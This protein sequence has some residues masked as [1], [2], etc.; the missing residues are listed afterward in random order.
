MIYFSRNL[1]SCF[2]AASCALLLGA[3]Q[4]APGFTGGGSN[5]SYDHIYT[6]ANTQDGSLPLQLNVYQPEGACTAPRP[7]IVYVH[8][9]S[10]Y[11]GDR[12]EGAFRGHAR[13]FTDAGFNFISIDYRLIPDSPQVSDAYRPLILNDSD[14]TQQ[15][16]TANA[17]AIE[18]TIAALRWVEI[19]G[20]DICH[21][22]GNVILFGGSAGAIVSLNLTYALDDFGL[23]AP[24]VRGVISDCGGHLLDGSVAK[25]DVPSLFIHGQR[26]GLVPVREA[27]ESWAQ[28]VNQ[29]VPAQIYTYKSAGHCVNLHR[30]TVN[31]QP[32]TNVMLE[33]ARNVSTGG[34]VAT[35]SRLGL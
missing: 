5:A 3:C 6:Y 2:A 26:D 29:G 14:F 27:Q 22:P 16:Y 19:Q 12:Y 31:G 1:I 20:E 11:I 15:Q 34:E 17:A 8:A 25:G 23:T 35:V 10:F 7:T 21:E 18:D 13:L 30:E 28:L 4:G 9:G 24:P 32:L 33:F